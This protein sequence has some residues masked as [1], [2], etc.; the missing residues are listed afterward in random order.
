[1]FED[2][3]RKC[4]ARQRV[5]ALSFFGGNLAADFCHR[6]ENNKNYG[7]DM[8]LRFFADVVGSSPLFFS[9]PCYMKGLDEKFA[10][11]FVLGE[12]LSRREI[13][14]LHPLVHEDYRAS[15]DMRISWMHERLK[16]F[17][18]TYMGALGVWFQE[19]YDAALH[20]ASLFEVKIGLWEP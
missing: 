8:W 9:E 11:W 14:L 4:V 1:M 2:E 5:K 3:L 19:D 6:V 20:Y 7:R 16:L 18:K 12:N 17:I 10:R 13:A 15:V